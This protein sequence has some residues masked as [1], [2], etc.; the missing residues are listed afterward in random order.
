MSSLRAKF[1]LILVV[2]IIAV[3]GL[4]TGL[5]IVFLHLN[6][7]RRMPDLVARQLLLVR[8]LAEEA[9]PAA[10]P[11]IRSAPLPIS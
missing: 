5:T 3:V 1:A 10:D 11:A 6:Q 4:A 7:S 8:A 9:R 2:A